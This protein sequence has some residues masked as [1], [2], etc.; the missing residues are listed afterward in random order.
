LILLLG[1]IREVSVYLLHLIVPPR[2]WLSRYYNVVDPVV[3]L[4]R[5]IVHAP[6]MILASL[7]SLISNLRQGIPVPYR[8]EHLVELPGTD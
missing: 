8:K 1:H 3:L 2:A 6:K 7:R 5:R 4:R